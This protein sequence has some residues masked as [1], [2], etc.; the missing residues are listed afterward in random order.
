[1]KVRI[2]PA[3]NLDLEEIISRTEAKDNPAACQIFRRYLEASV[4][5]WAGYADNQIACVWGVVAPTVLSDAGYLWLL[6]TDLVDEHKLSFI[7]HSQI[8]V[9]KILKEF[10]LIHGHVIHGQG[11]SYKWLKWLGVKFKQG[12]VASDG[13]TKLIPFELRRALNG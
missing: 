13:K 7:R 11:H 8:A 5:A 12:V 2:E 3:T 4:V 10:P 9:A 6:T 1:M